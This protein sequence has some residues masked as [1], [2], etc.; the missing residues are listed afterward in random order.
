MA[1]CHF[2]ANEN[3]EEWVIYN[4]SSMLQQMG[5][6]LREKARELGNQRLLAGGLNDPRF[7]EAARVPGQGKPEHLPPPAQPGFDV[8]DLLRR[9][10]HYVWNWRLLGKITDAY[11]PNLRFY[12]TT[13]RV[14]YGVGEYQ[15]FVLSLL[16][17]FPDLAF[18]VDDLYWMGNDL[19]G[20][21][22]STRWSLV[23]THTGPGVYGPPTG[24]RVY[25]WGITQH[26]IRNG[27]IAEEWMTFNEFDLLQQICH[28]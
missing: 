19:E 17:A 12:G 11:A 22:T 9:M 26:V 15:S 5:Y 20:Y 18:S 7:G 25:V 10:Y 1:N 16:A 13:D 27:R 6:D 14:L 2:L 21:T 8:E 4:T 3:R 28:D 24:R 23:G